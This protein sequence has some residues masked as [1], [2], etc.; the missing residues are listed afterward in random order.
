MIRDREKFQR[1]LRHAWQY[2]WQYRPGRPNLRNLKESDLSKLDEG[3]PLAAELV[4]GV[5]VSGGTMLDSIVQGCHR[6]RHLQVDGDA[7]PATLALLGVPR[8]DVPD[9]GPGSG[10]HVVDD[11]SL[12]DEMGKLLLT[13]EQLQTPSLGSGSWRH[14]CFPEFPDMHVLV[15][16]MNFGVASSTWKSH[17]DR[18]MEL[19][20]DADLEVGFYKIYINTSVNPRAVWTPRGWVPVPQILSSSHVHRTVSHQRTGGSVIGW[21]YVVRNH[22]CT[23]TANG[24]IS[25]GYSPG[26]EQGIRLVCRLELHECTHGRG[27]GH[28]RGIMLPYI[29]D[30]PVSWV[31]DHNESVQR[32]FFGGKRINPFNQFDWNSGGWV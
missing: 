9:W 6:G 32:R 19:S 20:T 25:T 1:I 17:L 24:A 4:E 28:S 23:S 22:S 30:G 16:A 2:G 15:I 3:H 14:S 13:A 8:C 27:L 12:V 11:G 26:G 21:N 5:Q 18:I 7:G 10:N 29:T 31:D